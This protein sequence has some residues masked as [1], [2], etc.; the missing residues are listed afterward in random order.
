MAY[1]P[2]PIPTEGIVLPES[3]YTLS[4]RLAEHVH[5][6]W[7]Y[8]RLAE[9]RRLGPNGSDDGLTHPNLVPYA[10]LPESE[11]DY[12][13]RTAFETLKAIVALGYRI[14]PPDG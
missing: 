14:V 13:R 5:D 4:E 9:G 8:W 11:K 6:V 3:L 1:R 2:Q 10:A 7:A 12:D